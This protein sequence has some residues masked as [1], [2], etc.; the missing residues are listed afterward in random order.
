ML[1]LTYQFSIYV[2]CKSDPIG[3]GNMY[4][5]CKL[6]HIVLYAG[7]EVTRSSALSPVSCQRTADQRGDRV[8]SRGGG[9]PAR[10]TICGQ[11]P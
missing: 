2:L 11:F 3:P 7:C 5:I 6:V 1:S 4:L 8:T 9:V 10:S